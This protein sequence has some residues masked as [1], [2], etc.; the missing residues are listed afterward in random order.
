MGLGNGRNA[1]NRKSSHGIFGILL[2][3]E[4]PKLGQTNLTPLSG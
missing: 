2:A 4:R 1:S 3:D